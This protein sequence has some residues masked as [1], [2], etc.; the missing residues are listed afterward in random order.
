MNAEES[1]PKFVDHFESFVHKLFLP[2]LL[3][4]MMY[5]VINNFFEE[6]KMAIRLNELFIL[7]IFICNWFYLYHYFQRD[8]KKNRWL[9][10]ILD[11]LIP[12]LFTFS[13]YLITQNPLFMYLTMILAFVFIGIY[14]SKTR[15]IK[16]LFWAIT[17]AYALITG[18]IYYYALFND[19]MQIIPNLVLALFYIVIL[20][21]CQKAVR[22]GKAGWSK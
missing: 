18:I 17:V 8:S 16:Y 14:I 9:Q 6:A 1:K 19:L 21:L 2:A 11:I 12:I 4:A 7:L 10:I 13:F 22:I 20:I 3:G 5:L 15:Y